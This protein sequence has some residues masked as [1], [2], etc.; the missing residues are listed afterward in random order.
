LNSLNF[1]LIK[2]REIR[3]CHLDPAANPAR[4]AA[5]LLHG[6]PGIEIIHTISTDCLQVQYLLTRTCLEI[7]EDALMGVGFH[8]DNSL[9]AKLKR[10]LIY[11]TEETQLMNLGQSH[12]QASYTLDIFINS[13]EQRLHGCRDPREPHMRYY[14]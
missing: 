4:E 8:L 1:E 6:A 7:I 10:S 14:S 2:Q 5:Q 3:F 11:Y 13:Y 9:M 12:D